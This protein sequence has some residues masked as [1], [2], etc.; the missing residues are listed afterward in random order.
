[1]TL[2]NLVSKTRWQRIL[3]NSS[4][5]A[6]AILKSGYLFGIRE[7]RNTRYANFKSQLKIFLKNYEFRIFG[8]KNCQEMWV[9]RIYEFYEISVARTVTRNIRGSGNKRTCEFQPDIQKFLVAFDNENLFVDAT[10]KGHFS[11]YVSLPKNFSTSPAAIFAS[12]IDIEK[13]IKTEGLILVNPRRVPIQ[14]SRCCCTFQMSLVYKRVCWDFVWCGYG[15]FS[16]EK[17]ASGP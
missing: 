3:I 7:I 6:A 5:N 15:L 12:P 14:D 9:L 13:L 11:G 2:N 16:F 1:V 4:T 17:C 8:L 10:A